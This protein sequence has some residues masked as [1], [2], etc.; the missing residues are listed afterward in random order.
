MACKITRHAEDREITE[1]EFLKQKKYG[2]YDELRSIAKGLNF[3]QIFGGSPRVFVETAL[4]TKWDKAQADEFIKENHL[5]DLRDKLKDRYQRDTP[6]MISYLTVATFMKNGFFE[7]YG[8]LQKRIDANREFAKEH[9]YVRTYFGAKRALIEELLRGSYD[10]REHGAQMRNLD[11]VCANTDIQNFEASVV[12][13][14]MVKTDEWLMENHK[15]TL[16]WNC[17]H[18][19]A[20]FYVHKSELAEVVAKAKEFFECALPELKGV[21]L[22]I[23]FAISDIAKGDYYK[24]GKGLSSFGIKE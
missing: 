22:K 4:E 18:D 17:V 8:G 5:G 1:Q 16:L 10:D 6:A 7:L 11:N 15:K 2:V 19:S 13:I 24:G 20:D 14:A 23:D 9:G 21:P 3:L 12:N